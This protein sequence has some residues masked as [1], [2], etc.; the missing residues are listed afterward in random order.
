VL[1]VDL[2]PKVVRGVPAGVARSP[3][4]ATVGVDEFASSAIADID[5]AG[6]D[7]FVLVGHSMGGLTVSEVA[8]RIPDRIEHL[9]F[10]SCLIP[11]DLGS[12]IDALPEEV[13]ELTRAAMSEAITGGPEVGM[14]GLDD[15]TKVHMFCNDLDDEQTQLMLTHLGA[16]APRAF[17]DPVTR[18]GIPPALPKT[19]VRLARDQA[20]TSEDQDRQIENLRASPGGELRVVE[21]DTGHMVMISAPEA[22]ATVLA[23]LPGDVMTAEVRYCYDDQ[24]LDEVSAIMG[25]IQVRRLPVLNRE[26]R[27]VGIIALGDIAMMQVAT[28]AALSGIS[29]PGGQHVQI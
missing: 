16:E 9:V 19:Y 15:A 17:A 12:I 28:S 4:L 6:I 23:E 20:L 26:K 13:R 8:R 25:D 14:G 18:V 29:R 21:L 24:E 27:L 2:P 3:A 11:P 10:V 22:L 1:A 7:R 5:A